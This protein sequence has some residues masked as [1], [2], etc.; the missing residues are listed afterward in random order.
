MAQAGGRHTILLVQYTNNE[1]SRTF[2]DYETISRCCM[3]VVEL[4]EERLRQLN[5]DVRGN[6]TYE[7]NDL[8]A[9]IDSLADISA[10]VF[11]YQT[12]QYAPEGKDWI[13]D[14]VWQYLRK[15]AR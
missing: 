13:K 3:G 5:P 7:L 1:R 6:I 2:L 8:F 12:Q 10:L 15:Q 11:D 14:K 4:Y 9:Y